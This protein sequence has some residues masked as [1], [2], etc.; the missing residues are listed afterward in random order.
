[1]KEQGQNMNSQNTKTETDG[2]NEP[3][4]I[5]TDKDEPRVLRS[6]LVDSSE[7]S[8]ADDEYDIGDPYNSTGRHVILQSKIVPEE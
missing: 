7:L 3:V 8:I 1:M 5:E 6:T 2:G 4:L